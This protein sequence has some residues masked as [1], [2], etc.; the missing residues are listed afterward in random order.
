[1]SV[2]DGM[3]SL[4][5]GCGEQGVLRGDAR[6]SWCRC[7]PSK[8]GPFVAPPGFVARITFE[9]REAA[10]FR[11]RCALLGHAWREACDALRSAS[12]VGYTRN[13]KRFVRQAPRTSRWRAL[14]RASLR[15]LRALEAI[16]R[17]CPHESRSM[18]APIFCDV[19]GEQV[20]CNLA[21]REHFVRVI[22]VRAA[23]RLA[24]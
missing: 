9:T 24:L 23:N 6:P 18:F 16:Q 1:M 22:G 20:E 11:E 8:Y 2:L 7:P 3:P 13:G 14:R 4:C 17:E 15:A 5:Q 12:W 10:A 19:C 21:E